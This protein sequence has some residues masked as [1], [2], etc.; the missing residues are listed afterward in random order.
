MA[1][2]AVAVAVLALGLVG[3]RGAAPSTT[4]PAIGQDDAQVQTDETVGSKIEK[5]LLLEGP[6]TLSGE[7]RTPDE[8]GAAALVASTVPG[9][10]RLTNSLLVAP[11]TTRDHKLA[12]AVWTALRGVPALSGNDT[13]KVNVKNA[14]VKLEGLVESSIQK[15]AAEKAVASVPGVA[16]VINLIEVNDKAHGAQIMDK[17][18]EKV[19]HNGAPAQP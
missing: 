13:V 14:V 5:S 7:I 8:K 11:A 6:P 4:A 3:F 15:E 2:G 9:V 19:R 12:Q 16:T 10:K 1:W 17:V 18:T